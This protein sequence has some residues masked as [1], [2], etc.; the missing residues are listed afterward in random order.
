MTETL[1]DQGPEQPRRVPPEANAESPRPAPVQPPTSEQTPTFAKAPTAGIPTERSF[2]LAIVALA[3]AL[4]LTCIAHHWNPN[5]WLYGDG[6]FYMNV[7]RGLLENG[8]FRQEAMHPHSWYDLDLG[9]NRN[10]DA[11]WSNIALGRN[12]EWWPKHP[13]LMPLA[14]TPFIWAFGPLG[15]LLFQL[16]GFVTIGLLSFRVASRV[17]PRTAALA[18]AAVFVATPWVTDR[19]WGFNNDVFFTA[20]VLAAV[21][22]ALGRR[23]LLA[24]A[25]LGIGVFAKNTN[26]LYGPALLALFLMDRDWKG[27]AR[28]CFAAAAPLLVYF[29]MNTYLYGAPYLTGYDRILVR[30]DG[31]L[32]THSHSADF[33]FKEMLPS[34]A[35]RTV[36]DGGITS[37]F[38][39]IWLALGGFAVLLIRRKREAVVLLWCVAVPIAFHSPF[40]WYRLDF[41]LPQMALAVA[42]MAALLM[43]F[44]KVSPRE[45]L[46]PSLPKPL[47]FLALPA[48][49][50]LLGA[51]HA[52][53]A[54]LSPSHGYLW[55]ELP[56]A[57]VTLGNKPCDYFNNQVERWECSHF[58]RGNDDQMTG[59]TLGAP[60]RF[61]GLP[62]ALVRMDPH[63]SG[64]P[65]AI[66]Y[67]GLPVGRTLQL[68]Y[69][70]AD[71][72]AANSKVEFKIM[73]DGATLLEETIEQRGLR[74]RD[75]ATSREAGASGTL[76]LE[77]RP[78][79]GSRG[80]HF[81][82]DGAPRP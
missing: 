72:S 14:A 31:L 54:A 78:L 15:S 12:G 66:Q 47:L 40:A 32:S 3:L 67:R 49:F 24:G 37:V 69:G 43:P 70:L 51:A 1:P 42:P 34:M 4:G 8:S 73:L 52:A 17:A 57:R 30:T 50:A 39:A 16:L 64:E 23:A 21:D 45:A 2:T 65:R 75:L 61:D 80:A 22:A 46:W 5:K 60:M 53:R 35:R 13:I 81:G 7:V 25:L 59:R 9:W 33:A 76:T 79:N 44:S 41:N 20:I 62:R 10:V 58:D 38:P 63:S 36:G 71:S 11:A 26:V 18:A 6:A 74:R 48:L 77:V 82:F 68:E 55:E 28:F 29:A 27:A 19:V 56:H